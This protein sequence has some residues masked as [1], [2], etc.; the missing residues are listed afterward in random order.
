MATTP[1]AWQDCRSYVHPRVFVKL[2]QRCVT[3]VCPAVLWVQSK[4]GASTGGGWVAEV[5]QRNAPKYMPMPLDF[6]L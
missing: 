1:R 3:F 6:L 4:V 5:Q 2:A